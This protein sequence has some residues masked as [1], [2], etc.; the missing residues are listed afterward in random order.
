MNIAA[1]Y[2]AVA[3][4]LGALILLLLLAAMRHRSSIISAD[5]SPIHPPAPTRLVPLDQ[6]IAP[7][8]Y[9]GRKH[10]GDCRCESCDP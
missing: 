10:P 2:L 3:P 9:E 1:Y 5:R 7:I 6:T 8:D 4:I